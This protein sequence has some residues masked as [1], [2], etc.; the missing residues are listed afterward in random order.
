MTQVQTSPT[1]AQLVALAERLG[2]LFAPGHPDD[3]FPHAIKAGEVWL[4]LPVDPREAWILA[5]AIQAAMAGLGLVGELGWWRPA[6]S[7]VV[8]HAAFYGELEGEWREGRANH[9]PEAP[10]AIVLAACAA[11]GVPTEEAH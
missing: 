2:F 11:L 7:D 6:G 5:G 9:V 4:P 8:F 10:D 1:D 3:H